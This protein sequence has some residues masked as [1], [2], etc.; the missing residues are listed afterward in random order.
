MRAMGVTIRPTT[1][2]DE[3]DRWLEVRNAV[4]PQP[5]TRAGLRAE[6]SSINASLDLI[7]EADRRVVGAGGVAWGPISEETR[8]VF[9]G[10]WVL[11]EHRRQGVGSRLY[12]QLAAFAR[13][14]GMER[15]MSGVLEGDTASIQ[16]AENRGLR[17]DGGGQ[18]GHLDLSAMDGRPPLEAIEDVSVTTFAERPDLERELYELDLLVHPEIPFFAA[19]PLP[20]F[21]AWHATAAGDPG[22]VAELSLVAIEADHVIGAVQIYDAADGTAFIGMT[23]VHP[24][25]RRRG[26]ARHM[27]LVLAERARAAGWRRLE[28]YNDGTN[29]RIRALNESLGYVYDPMFVIVRGPL[30]D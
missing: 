8:G 25:A 1:T 17:I 30:P 19:E 28:T 23:T 5:M 16:F 14:H 21:E 7:A 4:E 10:L 26:I 20:S 24:V 9:I 27:K 29:A 13:G 3:V 12:E 18:F 6:R 2:D 15:V 22:F 11:P